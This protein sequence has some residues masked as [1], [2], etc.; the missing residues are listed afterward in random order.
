MCWFVQ[1][2]SCELHVLC[3]SGVLLSVTSCVKDLTYWAIGLYSDRNNKSYI[4]YL[5]R[6]F[7]FLRHHRLYMYS[8]IPLIQNL[9]FYTFWYFS[10]RAKH[11][12]KSGSF[13]IISLLDHCDIS[14]CLVSHSHRFFSPK[15]S[16]PHYAGPI[17]K[18]ERDNNIRMHMW[19]VVQLVCRSSVK[20]LPVWT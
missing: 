10:S 12:L 11:I 14:C 17:A 9:I 18:D 5:F 20:I 2:T 13:P 1:R 16:R 8:G 3:I 7:C 15:E 19:L 4:V 6:H